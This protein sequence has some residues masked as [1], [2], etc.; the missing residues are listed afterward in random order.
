MR[1]VNKIIKKYIYRNRVFNHFS[2]VRERNYES[3]WD[4]KVQWYNQKMAIN[5]FLFESFNFDAD[6]IGNSR[7][8]F[9]EQGGKSVIPKMWDDIPMVE[10]DTIQP[11][12]NICIAPMKFTPYAEAHLRNFFKRANDS[13]IPYFWDIGSNK[14]VKDSML[15][16]VE[17]KPMLEVAIL[18]ITE[19]NL[20]IVGSIVKDKISWQI[21]TA[22]DEYVINNKETDP[23]R[24]DSSDNRQEEEEKEE[25]ATE[26]EKQNT[27]PAKDLQ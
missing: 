1:V 4:I 21:I 22:S 16:I 8:K 3:L 19:L 9:V 6:D 27:C 14:I 7:S 24:K 18:K 11:E 10:S 26:E 5:T 13:G 23:Y 2:R 20:N 25:E 17:L 15:Q 12:G